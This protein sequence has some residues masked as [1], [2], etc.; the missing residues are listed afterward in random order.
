MNRTLTHK[1]RIKQLTLRGFDSELEQKLSEL[2]RAQD[3]S[4]NKAAL[5]MLR[6]GAGLNE[7]QSRSDVIGD[8][9]DHLIGKWSE[10]QE[11][12][13]LRAVQSLEQVDEDMWK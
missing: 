8:T 3:I 7:R 4:L 12:E 6:K 5:M 13:F 10:R 1:R 9:L 11:K 2:A